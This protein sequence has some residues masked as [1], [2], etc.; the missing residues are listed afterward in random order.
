MM[1]RI[2]IL[3]V[4]FSVL[5]VSA[6]QQN[7]EKHYLLLSH[8]RTTDTLV[9][10]VDP[11]V[12]ALN[13]DDYD[14]LFLGGD[15]T[16]ESSKEKATL[17]YLDKLFDLGAPTT[18]WALGN[19]DNAHNDWVSEFTG[20]PIS[21]S[22]YQDGIT[23]VVLYTQEEKD[24]I[25]T[26]TGPQLEMLKSVTDTISS[27]SHLIVL[28]HKLVWIMDNP[29][30]ADHQGKSFYDWSCNYRIHENNWNSDILPRLRAVQDRGVQVICLGGDIGNNVR[31]FEEH[32]SDGI[33]YLASGIPVSQS[34]KPEAKILEFT[35]NPE[36]RTLTWDFVL[37]DSKVH[38]K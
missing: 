30:L 15:M 6:C 25:C 32:T 4:L 27:S 3:F 7:P 21:Y 26:I 9:Q 20:R 33:I 13:L 2:F 5:F 1:N 24:W 22:Y 11:R 17:E 8:T 38:S 18:L 16:E 28:S 12:E 31:T 34:L 29:E 14:M 35:H 37:L 19:H 10:G 23:Y 36:T